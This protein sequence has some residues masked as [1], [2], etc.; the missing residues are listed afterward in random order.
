MPT[1]SQPSTPEAG[2]GTTVR[3]QKG[4]ASHGPELQ[5]QR[6]ANRLEAWEPG[7]A[8]QG[9][10]WERGRLLSRRGGCG[11]CQGPGTVSR[12]SQFCPLLL[13]PQPTPLPEPTQALMPC[14]GPPATLHH[15]RAH[16]GPLLQPH[17]PTDLCTPA[18]KWLFI[19]RLPA[20]CSWEKPSSSSSSSS[21]THARFPPGDPSLTPA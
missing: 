8:G 12:E 10:R 11:Q 20:T 3:A 21:S 2:P 13:H 9:W 15:L 18:Q 5:K 17:A 19:S 6:V 1:S 14:L 7:G 4:P 16:E